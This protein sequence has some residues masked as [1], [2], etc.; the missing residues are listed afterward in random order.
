MNLLLGYLSF[1]TFTRLLLL[2]FILMNLMTDFSIP[3]RFYSGDCLDWVVVHFN[4]RI[5][6]M[7]M[8]R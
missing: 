6:V 5:W 7:A 4:S 2:K 8:K 3:F 1:F